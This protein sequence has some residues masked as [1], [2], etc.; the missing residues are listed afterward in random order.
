VHGLMPPNRTRL[1]DVGFNGNDEPNYITTDYENEKKLGEMSLCVITSMSS[2]ARGKVTAVFKLRPFHNQW[3]T[4]SNEYVSSEI[5]WFVRLEIFT[6]VTMK[7]A[8][9]L[10]VTPCGSCKSWRYGWTYRI[11]HQAK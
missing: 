6:A 9:L 7:N 5:N 8:V 1:Y 11:Y 2:I 3:M 10:D 4:M